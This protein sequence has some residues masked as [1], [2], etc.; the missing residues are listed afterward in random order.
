MK[1]L[2]QRSVSD[3]LVALGVGVS[4]SI[5]IAFGIIITV[6]DVIRLDQD[7]DHWLSETLSGWSDVAG[8]AI[9]QGDLEL[10]ERAAEGLLSFDYVQA[11][12]VSAPDGT[13]L[14]ERE[15]AITETSAVLEFFGHAHNHVP[16]DGKPVPAEICDPVFYDPEGER[17]H[18]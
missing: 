10:L 7:I 17:L 3:R 12:S 13:V 6:L 16:L 15:G 5:G 18:G 11:V 8:Y 14:F 1:H 9:A 2:R 4:L